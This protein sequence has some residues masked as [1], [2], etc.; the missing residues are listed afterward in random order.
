MIRQRRQ[1][2]GSLLGWSF[3]APRRLGKGAIELVFRLLNLRRRGS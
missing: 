2:V 1:M 3:I